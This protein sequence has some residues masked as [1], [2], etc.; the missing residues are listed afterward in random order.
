M[1]QS[2]WLG[3]FVKHVYRVFDSQESG[4]EINYSLESKV[5]VAFSSGFKI[6]PV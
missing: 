6:Y 3:L 1:A 2:R 4:Y 5:D